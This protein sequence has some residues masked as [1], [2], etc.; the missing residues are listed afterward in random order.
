MIEAKIRDDSGFI[1]VDAVVFSTVDQMVGNAIE[2][3]NENSVSAEKIRRLDALGF[4]PTVLTVDDVSDG[5]VDWV[6]GLDRAQ[7]YL[8]LLPMAL[9]S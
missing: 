7:Q 8:Q 5:D 2:F 1:I 4:V 6:A 9:P 3:V